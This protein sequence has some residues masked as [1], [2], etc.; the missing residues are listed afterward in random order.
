MKSCASGSA[1]EG[2][3][4]D[5]L[6]EERVRL[7]LSQEDLAQAGGVNRNTQGS[8]ERGVRNP[9][10]AYLLAVAELGVEVDFV[11][12]GKRSLDSGLDPEETQIIE[13]YR[14][15]PE[16]DQRALRRFLQAMFDDASR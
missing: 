2:S 7:N 16:Q 14:H 5:R 12:F 10:T 6:R 9:D 11:L 1:P 4:G 15:I 13:Q 8:Y 3:V